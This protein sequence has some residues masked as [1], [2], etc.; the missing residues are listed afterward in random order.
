MALE[1]LMM[2]KRHAHETLPWLRGK[3]GVGDMGLLKGYSPW[4]QE[5]YSVTRKGA[6]Q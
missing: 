6:L 3:H 1:R 5:K 2:V 4:I